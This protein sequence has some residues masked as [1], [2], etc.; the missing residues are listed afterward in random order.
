MQ[1]Y[2]RVAPRQFQ[3]E[4]HY[5]P[6]VLNAQMHSMVRY[7]MHLDVDRLVRRYV[8]LNPQADAAAL[9]KLLQYPPKYL[10]WAGSDLMH[11]TTQE[12]VRSMVI[13]ETNSCPSG[14]KSMPLYEEHDDLGGYRTVLARTFVPL[15]KGRRL[16]TGG[17]A[18]LR[19]KNA[20]ETSGY[21]ATL[22]ELTGEPVHLVELA[23]GDPEQPARFV[24][25]VLEAR[26][27]E[28]VWHPIRA[29]FRYVTQ[30]PWNRIPLRTK[31]LIFNPVVACLAG[32]RNKMVAAK[33][34]DFFNAE[35]EGT[36]LRIR[37]PKTIWDVA[38][39]EVS[40]WVAQLG[41]NAVIKVPYSNAGQGVFTVTSQRELD[42]FLERD[43][44]YDRV[45][46]QALIGNHGWSSGPPASRLYH[47]G[48]MPNRQGDSHAFDLR[49]SIAGGAGGFRPIAIYARRA[50]A[51]L[52][53]T[54]PAEQSSWAVLG[55][56]LSVRRD[57][58]TWDTDVNRLR[59]MD[60]KDF[61]G[62]GV[63]LDDLIEAYVQTV[64]AT[65][66]IDKMAIGLHNVKG[67]FRMKLFSS[68][69]DDPALLREI[70]VE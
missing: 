69:N 37:T 7:F 32:G 4:R 6:R 46:V 64:L 58:G 24:D 20:M 25:G 31:T 49:M 21:A 59:L 56:N 47:V 12:G 28:G 19:D 40:L 68:L 34:Y 43:H 26:D 60:R 48:T 41:G 27:G 10:R 44:I 15:L 67:R 17:L 38:H 70:V 55:T 35:L 42:E 5:Y 13:I 50:A 52:P 62:L 22:A 8:H 53:T 36:G 3:A 54:L 66:A 16:P 30:R 14:Q 1:K 23:D 51:P 39:N 65:I 57:D 18:V 2:T 61:N 29:A 9:H 63:G 45:I 33:A 11:V